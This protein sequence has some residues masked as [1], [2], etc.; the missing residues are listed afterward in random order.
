[1]DL[2]GSLMRNSSVTR[3]HTLFMRPVAINCGVSGI[4][5]ERIALGRDR[6]RPPK[7]EGFAHRKVVG[8][9]RLSLAPLRDDHRR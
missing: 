4:G 7:V 2:N 9:I 1:M 6:N 8:A 3:L 5:V